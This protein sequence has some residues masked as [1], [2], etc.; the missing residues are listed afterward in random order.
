M[1][2][3]EL[4]VDSISALRRNPQ[5]LIPELKSISNETNRRPDNFYYIVSKDGLIDPETGRY[6]RDVI[7][8][9]S[10]LGKTEAKTLDGIDA[11][12]PEKKE[13]VFVWLSPPHRQR[14][15]DT[16]TIFYRIAYTP[17]GQKVLE[18]SAVLFKAGVR[19]SLDIAAEISGRK[20]IDPEEL[21]ASPFYF[22]DSEATILKVLDLIS[23]Y[24][25]PQSGVDTY[26]LD[27]QAEMYAEMIED[28]VPEAVIVAQMRR[29]GFLGIYPIG[30]PPTFLEYTLNHSVLTKYVEN[31]G[32]C[33]IHIGKPISAGYNCPNCGGTYQGC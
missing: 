21:R 5:R 11:L 30:C 1:S 6:I 12:A 25:Q 24:S 10:L 18:N 28:G 29:T 3:K 14:S 19:E 4:A 32:K 33:G 23:L 9:S 2:S 26:S 17:E 8:R 15:S 27:E 13:G 16:K 31:C 7:D 20:F 22:E